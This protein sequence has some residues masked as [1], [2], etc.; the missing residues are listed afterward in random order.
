MKKRIVGSLFLIV[1]FLNLAFAQADSLELKA[2]MNKLDNALLQKNESDLQVL[3][4]R[5]LSFGHSNGWVQSKEALL[6]DS[7]TG[8]LNYHVIENNGIAV[9][10]I[11]KKW[12]TVKTN[13]H[14]EGVVNGT[15]FNL[16]L[17]V[18]QV[19]I[20]TKKGWQLVARQS[21]KLS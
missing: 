16:N 18:L 1:C 2:V 8:K 14:A 9:L 20:K 17:H 6:T 10:H 5:D 21:T 7:R 13:T 4:H 3:L 19:W 12:A 11:N 15:P